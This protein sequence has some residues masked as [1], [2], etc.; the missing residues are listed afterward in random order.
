MTISIG[1]IGCG[2]IANKHLKTISQLDELELTAVSDIDSGKMDEAILTY[3][4]LSNKE[5]SIK[6]HSNFHDILT[7][8]EIDIVV[9]ATI[10]S[11]HANMA[12]EAL[13]HNKHVILE[14]PLALS[15]SD[16]QKILQ[17][18]REQEKYILVCHQLRYRPVFRKI[19]NIIEDGS[20]GELYLGVASMR[21]HRP[22][23]YYKES[24]WKGSWEK[25]GGM[26]LNQG[27]HLIDLLVW[28]M[29]DVQMVFGD[30]VNK[31]KVKET[32]DIA[33]GILIFSNQ[34][35]GIIEAN[36][37]TQPENLGYYLS[38]FGEKGTISIGGSNFNKIE[39]C[40]TAS[41][42][43]KNEVLTVLDDHN[44]HMYM[45][46]NFI[47]VVNNK[48]KLLL[49]DMNDALQSLMTI[50]GI[51]ESSILNEPVNLPL[52][53]FTTKDM[54]GKGGRI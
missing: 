46:Q 3:Q 10:S 28:L 13:L 26:L 16:A 44:E 51:Y 2:Y 45:Y 47:N 30:I 31:S 52:D 38:I 25:D 18:A 41:P 20:L 33:S 4:Q 49:I 54:N 35:R 37:M 15:I 5:N 36:T 14:K 7:D 43:N 8:K 1:L 17:V 42:S 24:N 12:V 32:E 29:G 53:S 6:M 21:I 50:F 40:Y 34:A 11:L 9:I 27:I 48:E 39:R 19:K 23:S 22:N